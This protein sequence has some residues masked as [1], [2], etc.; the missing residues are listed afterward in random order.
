EEDLWRLMGMGADRLC[1]I[2]LTGPEDAP[3]EI[4]GAVDS[5]AKARVLTRAVKTLKGDLVLCGKASLDRQ[6]GLVPAYMAHL[7]HL[8]FLAGIL[9]LKLTDDHHSRITKNAGRGRREIVDC[10][11][12]ALFSVDLPPGPTL[13][14]A[15][16]AIQSARRKEIIQMVCD[17]YPLTAKTRILA[18]A[19]PR[20]RPKP[21]PAPDSALPSF[22]RI[23][24]LLSGSVTQKKG[25]QVTGSAERLVEKIINF[26]EHHGVLPRNAAD[27][28]VD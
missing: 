13:K 11:L 26:M 3:E 19:T 27:K 17:T 20:P 23:K 15:Y 8:P 21:I 12:P 6:N 1:R 9:D 22:V 24:Q 16:T 28:A 5:W 25:R 7:L 2:D 14:P 4:P 18:T 10:R